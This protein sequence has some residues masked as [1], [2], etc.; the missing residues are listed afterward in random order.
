LFGDNK[1]YALSL[2]AKLAEIVKNEKLDLIHAHYAIPHAAAAYLAQQILAPIPVPVVTTL[3]GTD[4]TLVGKAPNCFDLTK[5]FIE[6]STAVTAVSDY[7]RQQTIDIFAPQIPITRIHN[8]VDTEF[9]KPNHQKRGCSFAHGKNCEGRFVFLH[10]SNFRPVKRT[11]DVVRVFAGVLQ[12]EPDVC[13]HMAGEGPDLIKCRKLAQ[14]LGVLDHIC[15][16][17]NQSDIASVIHLADAVLFPS[18]EESFGLVPL[19]SMACGVPVIAS[20]SG[21]LP[22]VVTHGECGFL[23]DVGNI[24]EMTE[25]ALR[26]VRDEELCKTMGINGRNRAVSE[27]NLNKILAE[28]EAL[29]AQVL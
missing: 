16:L 14:E 11:E 22:E 9:F 17:G 29:Y 3:H 2:A 4:I 26:L 13:L 12:Q 7:L 21:G 25:Y 8:F 23:S 1:P 6:K 24:E 15:F 10:L 28:Y 20:R 18:Q 27:F 5:F 19:E